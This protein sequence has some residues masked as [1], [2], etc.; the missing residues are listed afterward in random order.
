MAI[1]INSSTVI[2]NDQTLKLS[3]GVTANRP[4]SPAVGTFWYNTQLLQLECWDGTK[5]LAPTPAEIIADPNGS[6]WGTN[7][8]GALG[9]NNT[10]S[11]SSPVLIGGSTG[12]SDWLQLDTSMATNGASNHSLG[13]RA[14]G[15]IYG[16]GA[17][18]SGQ[19]GTNNTSSFSSP[20]LVVGGFTDWR[21]V[22]TGANFTLAIRANGVA[23]AWGINSSGQLGTN[24]LSSFSSPV[25]V[26]GGFTD[27]IQIS[28]G[29]IHSI[30]LRAN[31]TIYGWGSGA[32]GRLGTGNTTTRS[33]PTLVVGSIVNWTQISAGI[34]HTLALRA[35]G[36][37]YAWGDN[38]SGKH[39]TGNTT[40]RSSP[41]LI[42]GG[43]TDWTQISAGNNHSLGLRANG[44]AYAWGANVSGQLGTNNTSS[45]SSPVSVVG[46]FTDWIQISAGKEHSLAIRANGVAYAWGQGLSGKL[47]NNATTDRSSPVSIVGGY[48]NWIQLSGGDTHSLGVRT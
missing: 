23:Y 2:F 42:V 1:K 5:W 30:G 27:W 24:N 16:W 25:S 37:A 6:A 26:V 11:R 46:G 3:S 17:N 21:R 13:L 20:V 44:V 7:S 22:T 18:P 41:V 29:D 38:T 8:S 48:T 28:A 15:T 35:D 4:A 45:F 12:F 9:T 33:S 40:A 31:G 14:N 34:S 47:G 39:G 36:T 10:S 43:F 32:N 19:L